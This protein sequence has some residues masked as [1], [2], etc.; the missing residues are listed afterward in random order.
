MVHVRAAQSHEF[1]VLWS[2]SLL[3]GMMVLLLLHALE[4]LFCMTHRND[5]SN[6]SYFKKTIIEQLRAADNLK[7][8]LELF[9]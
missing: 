8:F 2:S 1:P 3:A 5:G 7:L 9:L 4:W 6:K